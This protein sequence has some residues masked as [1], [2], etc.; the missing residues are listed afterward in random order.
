M[1]TDFP[2][3]GIVR[4]RVTTEEADDGLHIRY[5]LTFETEIAATHTKQMRTAALLQLQKDSDCYGYA[6][7]SMLLNIPQATLFAGVAGT[8]HGRKTIT[9]H[10]PL[11]SAISDT[12]ALF[13]TQMTLVLE[14][15]ESPYN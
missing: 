1:L 7:E 13:N 3:M 12:Q 4:R 8:G 11:E 5:E 9:G 14:F 2:H 15:T 6:N 10:D